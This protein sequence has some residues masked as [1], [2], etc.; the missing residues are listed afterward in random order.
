ML[1]PPTSLTFS[2]SRGNT[3][4]SRVS[5]PVGIGTLSLRLR[6]NDIAFPWVAGAEFAGVVLAAPSTS[7][8]RPRFAVGDRV[9]GAS[10]GAFATKVCA[11][12]AQLQPV[13]PGWS[14]V[15]AGGLFVT[16]PT[17]Y[18]ALVVRA[19]IK[20]GDTVLVHAAAGGVGLA[21]VQSRFSFFKPKSIYIN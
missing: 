19:G 10:Q 2:R 17:S 3:R 6:A 12:E 14:Y 15:E 9:F 11:T 21:A 7:V 1:P 5:S 4:T 16:A 20:R 8:V 18:A 13:P